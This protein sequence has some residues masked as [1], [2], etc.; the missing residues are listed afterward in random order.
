[1]RGIRGR[2]FMSYVSLHNH[3]EYSN[4][5]M[6]DCT[7]KLYDLI[8]K[9]VELGLKGL[10]ITDHESLSGH[11]KA[12]N[13]VKDGKAK[14]KI[15]EDFTLGCGN[16]I[17]LVNDETLNPE[18]YVSGQ[19]KFYHFILIAK[20]KKGHELLRRLSTQAWKNRY[21]TGKM[22]RVPI[23]KRQ[24]E[25]IIGDE[26]GHLIAS[27]GCVGGELPDC[28]LKNDQD[29]AWEFV[30][31]CWNVFGKD[32]FYLEMQPN[33]SEDQITV[34]K[35]LLSISKN[36]G[37]K[38]VIT[39]DT[40]YLSKELAPIHEA[41][42]K[43]RGSDDREVL[44]FYSSC[45]MQTEEEIYEHM[46]YLEDEVMRVG[47]EN[48]LEIAEKI[49]TYDLAHSQVVP[50][51]P[52]KDFAINGL[53]KDYYQK[54]PYLE[55]FATSD[56]KHDQ[57]WL[58]LIEEGYKDKEKSILNEAKISRINDE[59]E[60]VWESSIKIHDKISNY[61]ITYL[62]IKN[63]VWDDSDEGG[64]SIVGVGRGSVAAFYTGFLTGVHDVNSF[65]LNIP[66]WR[67]L[68]AD[69]PEMPDVDFDSEARQR[70]RILQATKK[71]FGEDK[72]LNICTFK[73]E[74]PRS[75]ILTAARGLDIPIE[76]A[77]TLSNMI[78]VKRGVTYSLSTMIYGNADD[79]IKPDKQF[80]DTCNA[81]N[82]KLL[83]Y[84][85]SIEGLVSGR[86]VHASGVIIFESSYTNLNAMMTAPS[87]QEITQFDM[88]DS[89]YMGGL[90]YDYLTVVNLDI[91]HTCLD[92]L[93]ENKYIKWQGNLRNT[94][95][96][97][98]SPDVLD[99]D[100]R[101]MWEQAW[102]GKV[103]NLFQFDTAVGS[104]VIKQIKPLSL[105]E[106]GLANSLER[107]QAQPGDTEQPVD[108]YVRYKNNE[109]EWYDCMHKYN[110]TDDEIKII[111]KYLKPMH[112]I[113]T[114]QE[115][116]M[117]LSMDPHITN[118]SVKDSNKLRKLIAKK[119][120]SMQ[121]EAKNHFYEQ[122]KEIGTSNNMLDYVWNETIRP[123]LSYSFSAPHVQSYSLIA[124]Q[125]MNMAY[126]YP[127]IIWD[128]SCLIINSGS[129]EQHEG[130]TT[131]YG[132]VAV[133]IF[134]LQSQG[135]KV[136]LPDI[137]T[138][139]FGFKPDV[140]NNEI[141]YALKA[142]SGVGDDLSKR[143]IANR[144]YASYEDFIAKVQS[145]PMETA[146]LIKAGAFTSIEKAPAETT[147]LK[148]LE[149]NTTEVDKLTLAQLNRCIE[150]GIITENSEIY[151][152]YRMINFK[153]YV[154]NEARLYKVIIEP[155][156]KLP[157]CQYH[158]RHF[159]LD[160]ASQPFFE[161]YFSEDSIV[162]TVGNTYI[163][164]EKL[165][166]KE[167]KKKY[168]E[169]LTEWLN[170]PD[171]ISKYNAALRQE[172]YKRYVKCSRKHWSFDTL[173]YY[174][175]PHELSVVDDA[176]YGIV[177]FYELSETPEPFDFTFRWSNGKQLPIPL[178]PIVRI[179]G[180][181]CSSDNDKH[182]VT[183]LT[184]YGIV[185]VKY[186]KGQYVF[187]NKRATGC[188]SWF[189]RGTL[190]IV[191][192]FRDGDI[193]RVKKYT[194]TI[195]RHTTEKIINIQSDGSLITLTERSFEEENA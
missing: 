191:C 165:F 192:G 30:Q 75:A 125:E 129:D 163:I 104:Q 128:T 159:R 186:N 96:K 99:Y 168:L 92:L 43:S 59:L 110:L 83:E 139:T 135:V 27:S 184:E 69:R 55:K 172:T 44:D 150:Y 195:Y 178:Y 124:I 175:G 166:E 4:L 179:A 122:G 82:S 141:L 57:Y 154:L 1:M 140:A 51:T 143:I 5:R 23:S 38:Y 100:T 138:S 151:I 72:V 131:D 78:T 90:K 153:K 56:D 25:D 177:N 39:T 107:L 120:V 64:N 60:A 28:I 36:L 183:L 182:I 3:T 14:G 46:S 7:N 161:Q 171:V 119:K 73:T 121:E 112:G 68:H 130:E 148:F 88:N 85:L 31:W 113:A 176:V 67:H 58:Y 22:E 103:P 42:L 53:F 101:E 133:A 102:Y 80:I 164:S 160:T 41:Y 132:A 190:L 10:A 109:N 15:P 32:D 79:N 54:Y 167:V 116:V 181:V 114:M 117:L 152:N 118:Y 149:A 81:L 45:Y 20:D 86:S 136:S 93:V 187:Y 48:T 146:T 40:H 157:K 77:E 62:D 6:L 123:M 95:N 47:L 12:M 84:S 180:T 76:E 115:D 19:T 52:I 9:A 8:D 63:M 74:G 98:F 142:I 158:D 134:N 33:Q 173:N 71:K 144:P 70:G 87:G 155:D 193:F 66:Y 18:N 91:L 89:T 185:K 21:R 11:I 126:H 189:K 188:P 174:D 108:K 106:L 111:E 49:E 34:N 137:N 2:E 162:S 65:E 17:Y 169:P 147:M 94:F 26:K 127:P 170:N 105:L 194:N 50:K 16:E 24:V 61:Y 145:T 35:A 97:Y 156:K 29:R 13:Y 37:I